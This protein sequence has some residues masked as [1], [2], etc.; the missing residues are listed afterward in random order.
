MSRSKTSEAPLTIGRLSEQSGVPPKTIR[1]YEE[2]GLLPEPKRTPNGYR[3]YD[4]RSVH[5]LRFVG[6]ARELG[7]PMQ[8]IQDLLALWNNKW[9]KSSNVRT[10]AESHLASIESKIAKLQSMHGTLQHLI[11]GCHGDDR[12]D[13]PILDELSSRQ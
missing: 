13:C 8:D 5:I 2:V 6:R 1:Y 10:I 9:R 7:F 3:C 12:P 4:A 11:H